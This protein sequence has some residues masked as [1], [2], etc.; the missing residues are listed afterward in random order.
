MLS[1][2]SAQG[3]GLDLRAIARHCTTSDHGVAMQRRLR[4]LKA[5]TALLYFGALLAGLIG[6]GWAMVPAFVVVFLLWSV[7]LRPHLWP[8]RLADLVQSQALVALAALVATQVLLVILCFAIGRGIGGVLG[9][10]P[11]MPVYLPLVLSC[12]AVPLSRLIWNPSVQAQTVGSGPLHGSSMDPAAHQVPGMLAQVMALPDTVTEADV[13]PLLQAMARRGDALEIRQALG[14]TQAKRRLTRAGR[15]LLILHATD[16]QVCALMRGSRYPALAYA[17]AGQDAA[18]L[19]LFARRCA[20]VLAENCAIAADCPGAD[21]VARA[22]Q[23]AGGSAAAPVLQQ[24]AA[25]LADKGC[26]PGP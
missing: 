10:Q 1:Q 8:T 14:A 5:A 24:L 16:P 7:V 9:L 25:L 17:A 18:L 2:K 6:Q 19:A 26:S 23:V 21:E 20:L 12:L 13:L 4:L 22:A 3:L 11:D 15:M